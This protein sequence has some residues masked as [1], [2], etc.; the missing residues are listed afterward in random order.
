MVS[1][2]CD[3]QQLQAHSKQG[4]SFGIKE[5]EHHGDVDVAYGEAQLIFSRIRPEGSHPD[6]QD[7]DL[8]VCKL[9]SVTIR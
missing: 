9:Q 5:P 2:A 6:D 7:L 3:D 8:E 1:L 4:D